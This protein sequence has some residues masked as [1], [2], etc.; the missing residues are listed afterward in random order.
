MDA[1]VQAIESFTSI[2]ATPI[3]DAWAVEAARLIARSLLRA[4]R[5]GRDLAAR[6][7]VAYG[8]LMAGLALSNARLGLV[9]GLAHPLG[10]RYR[11]PHGLVCAV[12]LLPVMRFNRGACRE[13]YARLDAVMDGDADAF[14]AK[15]M[16]DLGVPLDLKAFRVN[17]ADVPRIVEESLPSGSLKANPRVPTAADC[18]AIVREII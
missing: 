12:L 5:D 18:G 3:T 4:F 17:L 1:L 16:H 13:K 9:H 15:L 11:I 8:S 7:D 14:I 6:S 10:A 2:H